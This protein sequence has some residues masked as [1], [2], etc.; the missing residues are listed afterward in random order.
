MPTVLNMS[1]YRKATGSVE[2]PPGAV[3]I[4]RP[5]YRGGYR[6]PGSKWR[7]PFLPDKDDKK[8]DG[9]REEVVAKFRA[10]LCEDPQRV[11]EAKAELRG[12]DLVCWC[13]PE[14]CHGDVLLEM[15]NGDAWSQVSI[16]S[17]DITEVRS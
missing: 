1:R 14:A 15:A 8:R 3:Y 16:T 17:A 6:I 13:A 2:V 5:M 11:A 10:W 9:T 7:N 4:G 12:R